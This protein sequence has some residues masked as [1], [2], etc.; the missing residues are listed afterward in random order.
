MIFANLF[1]KKTKK[2][3]IYKFLNHYLEKEIISF[4]WKGASLLY[5]LIC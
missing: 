4:P 2:N 3:N 5:T 1:T